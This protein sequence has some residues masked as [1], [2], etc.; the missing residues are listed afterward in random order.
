MQASDVSKHDAVSRA[1]RRSRNSSSFMMLAP[2]SPAMASM[3][4]QNVATAS[5]LA[6]AQEDDAEYSFEDYQKVGAMKRVN[7]RTDRINS[8]LD[9]TAMR[10]WSTLDDDENMR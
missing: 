8:E 3:R 2:T 6:P 5:G 4:M 9:N 10:K 7:R 1:S